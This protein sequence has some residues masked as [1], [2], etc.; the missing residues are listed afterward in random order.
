[1]INLFK[2]KIHDC[3]INLDNETIIFKGTKK[4]LKKIKKVVYY[5]NKQGNKIIQIEL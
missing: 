3:K 4:Q 5:Y 1:M 2:K